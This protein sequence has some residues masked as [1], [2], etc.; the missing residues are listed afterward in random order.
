LGDET[1][2]TRLV[3][4]ETAMSEAAEE[5]RL[6]RSLNRQPGTPTRKFS[7]ASSSSPSSPPAPAPAATVASTVATV[8]G[9]RERRATL[10]QERAE[11]ERV[12]LEQ[13][14]AKAAATAAG[15][16]VESGSLLGDGGVGRAEADVVELESARIERRFQA[17]LDSA[18]RVERPAPAFK[19]SA[20]FDRDWPVLADDA[21]DSAQFVRRLVD[22]INALRANP[23]AWCATLDELRACFD[24]A[25]YRSPTAS[26]V[27]LDTDE[28]LAAVQD[29]ADVLRALTPLA[30]LAPAPALDAA[31]AAFTDANR[32]QI[33][34]PVGAKARRDA[35]GSA[36]AY[37]ELLN[38]GGATPKEVIFHWLL[39]D[40]NAARKNRKALLNPAATHIGAATV[41]NSAVFQV[42]F[43]AIAE[44]F[45][46][47]H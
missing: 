28:S 22:E 5:A 7:N 14:R 30:A 10:D 46:A 32:D 24:G 13:R 23:P 20:A 19:F 37:A 47:K 11:R 42:T 44:Q 31:C 21:A 27:K 39:S 25:T 9:W 1:N 34:P 18:V 26:G 41:R 40:G 4:V 45:V 2:D 8:S 6:L 12:E 33:S 38:V 35:A 17:S 3:I 29:A 43:C 36:H 16:G 15:D